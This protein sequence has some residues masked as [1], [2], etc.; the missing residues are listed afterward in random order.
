MYLSVLTI[1]NFRCFGS[2]AERLELCLRRGLTALVGEN[3][4]GKSAIIDAL[5][6]V[7]GTT[8]QEWYQLEDTD[9]HEG[10]KAREISIVCKFKGL[11]AQDKR[12]FVE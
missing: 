7:L 6:F 11:N 1:E 9:F 5:R 3:D 2:G 8:D 10:E 4:A 12:A